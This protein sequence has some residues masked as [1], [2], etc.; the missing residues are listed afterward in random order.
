MTTIKTQSLSSKLLKALTNDGRRRDQ[1]QLF[2]YV[3]DNI[4]S[5]VNVGVVYEEAVKECVRDE[6]VV[7]LLLTIKP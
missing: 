3:I 6:G 1:L 2:T 7:K 4:V 5:G